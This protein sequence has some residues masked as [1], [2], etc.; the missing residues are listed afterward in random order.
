ML[1]SEVLGC[2][3]DFNKRCGGLLFAIEWGLEYNNTET[4]SI[5]SNVPYLLENYS[6]IRSKLSVLL[7]EKKL[8][9]ID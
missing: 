8:H 9:R 5:A 7:S 6:R 3:Q 2:L 4:K 1:F